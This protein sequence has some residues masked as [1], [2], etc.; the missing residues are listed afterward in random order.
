MPLIEFSSCIEPLSAY[1]RVSSLLKLLCDGLIGGHDNKHLDGH[2]EDGH[3]DQVGHIVSVE[4]TM[5]QRLSMHFLQ[6]QKDKTQTDGDL[7]G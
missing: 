3:G 1:P 7:L 4:R 2:V 6:R 5:H